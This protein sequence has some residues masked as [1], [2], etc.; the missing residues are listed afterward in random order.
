M[1][2]DF[3][4]GKIESDLTLFVLNYL[5]ANGAVLEQNQ[6]ITDVLLPGKL[7]DVLNVKEYISVAPDIDTLLEN[8]AETGTEKQDL[9]KI[10]FGSP[11]LEKIVSRAGSKASFL[12]TS[13]KFNYIKTQGFENLINEQFEF[14]KCR[15]SLTGT[16]ET[17]T[18]YVFLTCQFTARSDEL[19][20]GL[21]D[22]AFNIETTAFVPEMVEMLTPIEK[23]YEAGS[24]HRF[25]DDQIKRLHKLVNLYGY[26]A[27]AY[28]LENFI[29]SMNRRFKRDSKSLDAYYKALEKEM[30]DNLGRAGMSDKLVKE[31]KEKVAMLPKELAAK[32]KDLLNKYSIKIDFKPVAVMEVTT[33]CVKLF[34]TL[35]AGRERHDITIVYNPVTKA[36][37]PV[38]CQSCGISTYAFGICSHMHINCLTCLDKRCNAC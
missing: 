16:G 23:E 1:N 18:Q 15:P 32:K 36:A 8:K 2:S 27:V 38:V 34:V 4:T 28:R 24:V 29:K 3:D 30:H 20:Q 13:L 22:F 31:R 37:D 25:A 21:I 14:H 33:P 6:E 19:K 9:Y 10:Q 26:D 11:L 12:K 7:C 17:L 5:E 35:V